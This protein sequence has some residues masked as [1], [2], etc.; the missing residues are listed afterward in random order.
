[1]T[2]RRGELRQSRQESRDR[3]VTA[4]SQLVRTRSYAALTVDDV[5]Q[6]AGFGR[7]IFYRHFDD[8]ADLLL[9]AGREAIDELFTV[10]R[11]FS[12]ARIDTGAHV[13]RGA[14]E[15]A[16]AIYEQHGPLLRAIAEAAAGGDERVEQ[17]HKAM[18]ERFNELLQQ[19]LAASP[20]LAAH[21]VA[22]LA[23]TARALNLLNEAYLMEAFG[24]QPR[25]TAEVALQT[26]T[27]IWIALI[28][29]EPPSNATER[30]HP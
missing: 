24:R 8:L 23:E 17:A 11:T 27:E 29:G 30:P 2:T 21:P 12:E 28:H 15:P 26:L 10:Q 6:E 22:S 18:R 1:M 20:H 13:V 25:V 14:L 7:T 5:M 4:A 19:A 3:I 16:V 9:R